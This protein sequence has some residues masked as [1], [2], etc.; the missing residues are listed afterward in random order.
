MMA[1]ASPPV[2]QS[3]RELLRRR[4]DEATG[5]SA[6]VASAAVGGAGRITALVSPTASA[7]VMWAAY[8]QRHLESPEAPKDAA[9]HGAGAEQDPGDATATALVIATVG[10]LPLAAMEAMLGRA[11]LSRI[12][13][14]YVRADPAVAVDEIASTLRRAVGANFRAI[15]VDSPVWE[16]PVDR[17]AA[18]EARG[19]VAALRAA[20]RAA[21]NSG[22][23]VYFTAPRSRGFAGQPQQG[24][25]VGAAPAPGVPG[26]VA[27]M[28]GHP[29][30]RAVADA[31][32]YD[33][34]MSV[35]VVDEAD[36]DD[37][38]MDAA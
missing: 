5:A 13:V 21:A 10:A 15:V 9:D 11:A 25:W 4:H 30:W 19:A 35:A 6:A 14:V 28:G 7:W 26:A 33:Q 31:V 27:R 23:A 32:V 29:L 34:Q 12:A 18:A 36:G 17:A 22:A 37:G 24:D 20:M 1:A 8:L 3:L 16:P 38:N 2:F